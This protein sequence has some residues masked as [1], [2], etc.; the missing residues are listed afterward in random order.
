MTKFTYKVIPAPTSG[1]SGKGIK[2][3]EA[4]F[5]HALAELMNELAA[6]GWEY[7]R[8]ESLPSVERR[9]VARKRIETYQNVLVFRKEADQAEPAPQKEVSEGFNPFKRKSPATEAKPAPVLLTTPIAEKEPDTSDAEEDADTNMAKEIEDFITETDSE[10][11]EKSD[12][13]RA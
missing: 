11:P 3:A 9:G 2:G 10:T 13:D 6:E 8:A 12:A 5:A 4:K 7:Q 1:K